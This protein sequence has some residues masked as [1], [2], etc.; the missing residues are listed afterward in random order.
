V[1]TKPN[2]PLGYWLKHTDEMLTKHIN[3][4]Q[5]VN[6]V[7]RSQWQILNTL[8]E[9]SAATKEQIFEVM[10][11]FVDKAELEH[12]LTELSTRGWLLQVEYCFQL[13][14]EGRA[15]HQ[16]ILEFQKAVRQ[17]AMQGISEEEYTAVISVLQRIVKNLE[18]ES[19]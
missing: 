4:A 10:Q 13:T 14:D 7:S 15:K 12:I 11:T 17:R 3:A 8:Y 6:G 5:S 19:T 16:I 18:V 9:V 1:I 2:L